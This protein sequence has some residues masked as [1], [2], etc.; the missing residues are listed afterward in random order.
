M[1]RTSVIRVL[2]MASGPSGIA[3]NNCTIE[4]S[5]NRDL[6]TKQVKTIMQQSND[7]NELEIGLEIVGCTKIEQYN[8]LERFWSRKQPWRLMDCRVVYGLDKENKSYL[9]PLLKVERG[10]DHTCA[11]LRTGTE[12]KTNTSVCC[13]GNSDVKGE[14]VTAWLASGRREIMEKWSL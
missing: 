2:N 5:Y 1:N 13:Y 9:P 4:T 12:T 14:T 11:S 10:S 8:S 7:W 6:N 3:L